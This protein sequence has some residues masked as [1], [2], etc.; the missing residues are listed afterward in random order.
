MARH[1]EGPDDDGV[2]EAV[3]PRPR[4]RM[5]FVLWAVVVIAI[6][7]GVLLVLVLPTRAWLDQRAEVNDAERKLAVL[8]AANGELEA[9][10]AALQTPAEIE[11]VARQQY[12]LVK[13]GERV[14]SVQ[15]PA[16]PG[17]LPAGWPFDLV[18]QIVSVRTALPA[19]P[20]PTG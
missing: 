18:G 15:P 11:R 17:G 1:D 5:L 9:R 19:A 2:D 14:Y 10:V 7:G 16:L 12:S 20:A 13:P 6:A 3:E 4:Y 8:Q